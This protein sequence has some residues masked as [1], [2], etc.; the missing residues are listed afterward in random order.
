[1]TFVTRIAQPPVVCHSRTQ[2]TQC[3][4][5]IYS[6]KHQADEGFASML[7]LSSGVSDLAMM[8][9]WIRC[10]DDPKVPTI[11][12]MVQTT[13]NL[14]PNT[15]INRSQIVQEYHGEDAFWTRE[16]FDCCFVVSPC[17]DPEILMSLSAL[18]LAESGT[19]LTCPHCVSNCINQL[20]LPIFKIWYSTT[21]AF[22]SSTE[23][24]WHQN[25][26][27]LKNLWSDV[28]S[29]NVRCA[30]HYNQHATARAILV[31]TPSGMYIWRKSMVDWRL[32]I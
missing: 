32:W 4:R 1:M 21:S 19:I 30:R 24:F 16:L 6:D 14:Q 27:V 23:R 20:S 5:Q 18:F 25:D 17:T 13:P 9:W 26:S 22:F 3:P 15:P 12:T 7:P 29:T 2:F 8:F 28:F 11:L 10:S 31:V